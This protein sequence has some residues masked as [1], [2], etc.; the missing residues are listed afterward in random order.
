[1]QVGEVVG[2]D[3]NT[4]EFLIS[5]SRDKSLMIWDIQEKKETDEDK[6]WGHPRKILKGHSHFISELCLSQDS[7]YVLSSSWDSTLRLW[8]IKKGATTR[9]FVSHT[10]DVLS[11]SFSPDN[12]QIASG[13]RDK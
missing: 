6:E 11:A 3:G 2:E 12:R 7:R 13:G 8:D 5:G 1:M 10:K 9:R 4:T